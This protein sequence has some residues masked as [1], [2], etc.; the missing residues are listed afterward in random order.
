MKLIPLSRGKFTIVD[1]EDYESLSKFKWHT[2]PS[3][4]TFYATRGA[5]KK[6]PNGRRGK[7]VFNGPSTIGMARTILGITDP[8]KMADHIDG[9]GLNNQRS[10]L[11]IADARQNQHNALKK[12]PKCTSK[13]KGVSWNKHGSK[14]VAC[15]GPPKKRSKFY[16]DS[17]KE[18]ALV[19]NA[20]ASFAYREFAKLNEVHV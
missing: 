4:G 9:D 14:W 7:P 8:K 19:Y 15:F 13:Y 6:Y 20:M 5:P 1:D 18:A 17:E 16:C 3:R 2:I 10:N 12:N 11:R